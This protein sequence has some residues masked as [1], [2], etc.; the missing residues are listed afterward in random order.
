MATPAPF[1]KTGCGHARL[2]ES[3]FEDRIET[4]LSD[5]A[6][7]TLF[8]QKLGLDD[9]ANKDP[10]NSEDTE[11]RVNRPTM[12]ALA[13]LTPS[14]KSVGASWPQVAAPFWMAPF[15]PPIHPRPDP[16]VDT[17]RC[18]HPRGFIPQG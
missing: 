16:D 18:L 7:K 2:D 15:S 12:E 1:R 11:D 10:V 17:A 13:N 8:L 9:L 5:P 6:K 14:G 3:M 4:L